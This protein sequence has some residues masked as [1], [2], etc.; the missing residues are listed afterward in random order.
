MNLVTS[1]SQGIYHVAQA[2]SQGLKSLYP[3]QAIDK[4][5]RCTQYLWRR[6]C[7]WQTSPFQTDGAV[8]Y[9][10]RFRHLAAAARPVPSIDSPPPGR[11]RRASNALQGQELAAAAQPAAAAEPAD[12][13]RERLRGRVAAVT[14]DATGI[15]VGHYS[16][17]HAASIQKVPEQLTELSNTL[18]DDW[19]PK[20]FRLQKNALPFIQGLAKAEQTKESVAAG[21]QTLL[22]KLLEDN[23]LSA[24]DVDGLVEKFGGVHRELINKIIAWLQTSRHEGVLL[25]SL[26]DPETIQRIYGEILLLLTQK[27]LRNKTE[28]L[29]AS[30]ELQN[31]FDRYLYDKLIE[32]NAVCLADRIVKHIWTLLQGLAFPGVIDDLARALA[33]HLDAFQVARE[34]YSVIQKELKMARAFVPDP[35]NFIPEEQEKEKGIRDLLSRVASSGLSDELYCEQQLLKKY[36]AEKG[37][38]TLIKQRLTGE[39]DEK[40]FND[41][42]G[43][44]TKALLEALLPDEFL[45]DLCSQLQLPKEL[46][47]WTK[48]VGMVENYLPK[49]V[50][51]WKE[52]KLKYVW[53]VA[54]NVL[55][56]V[57]VKKVNKSIQDTIVSY[58]QPEMLQTLLHKHVMPAIAGLFLNILA[59]NAITSK[60][61]LGEPFYRYAQIQEPTTRDKSAIFDQLWKEV[62]END[63]M[64]TKC[65]VKLDEFTQAITQLVDS[66]S[67]AVRAR[68]QQTPFTCAAEVAVYLKEEL[69]KPAPKREGQTEEKAGALPED[70]LYLD[71]FNKILW[72][73]GGFLRAENNA[74]AL[75]RGFHAIVDG[76]LK[77]AFNACLRPYRSSYKSFVEI[78]VD[79]LDKQFGKREQLEALLQPLLQQS[80]QQVDGRVP[81]EGPAPHVLAGTNLDAQIVKSA[82]LLNHL[83]N[84]YE[85]NLS[86]GSWSGW[87]LSWGTAGAK[88]IYADRAEGLQPEL[89]KAITHV[90][91]EL[92]LRDEINQSL[93]LRTFDTVK[94]HLQLANAARSQL[95]AV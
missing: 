81:Q 82:H 24:N 43:D 50:A 62:N 1:V 45:L 31:G 75:E 11:E 42:V 48:T 90:M 80:S 37:V 76:H 13:L 15:V 78:W 83:A 44:V 74:T 94:K 32:P 87:A 41:Y 35:Q 40:L 21:E 93:L 66:L 88:R 23:I 47:E 70:T 51:E 61:S 3:S 53:R 4:V 73:I 20:L 9:R 5:V 59:Q 60:A 16:R 58:S 85:A 79:A 22:D 6:L 68:H 25:S 54:F 72:E 71:L 91:K 26:G 12:P 27:T 18:A 14:R 56:G 29:T 63:V 67:A 86:K 7:F 17:G 95:T 33:Q 30:P 36:G 84:T 34:H 89:K 55:K 77:D 52:K 2:G 8:P 64:L 10:Q 49:C 57:I 92:F 38:P 19:L 28:L 46:A 39:N 65:G 69:N